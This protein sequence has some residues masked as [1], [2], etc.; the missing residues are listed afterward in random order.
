[1]ETI[2]FV[3]TVSNTNKFSSFAIKFTIRSLFLDICKRSLLFTIF[4]N[5]N[6]SIF[7]NGM[8]RY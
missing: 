5:D 7:E 8:T 1:L 3:E 6:T 2:L 4:D